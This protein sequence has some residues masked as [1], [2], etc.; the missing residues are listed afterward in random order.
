MPE[1]EMMQVSPDQAS[2]MSLKNQPG[3][4]AT[5]VNS[6]ERDFRRDTVSK[7]PDDEGHQQE[8]QGTADA[9]RIETIPGRQSDRDDVR[10]VMFR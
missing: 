7:H 4:S 9:C 10:H 6:A 2:A 1:T 3:T 5:E 8:H